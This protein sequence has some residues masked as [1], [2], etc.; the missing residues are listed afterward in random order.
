MVIR[1]SHYHDSEQLFSPYTGNN[2]LEHYD[3]PSVL[4]I[5]E[6]KAN[7]Y[8]YLHPNF[9]LNAGENP[10][11]AAGKY[12]S[13]IGY[14]IDELGL[15]IGLA[16]PEEITPISELSASPAILIEPLDNW[17]PE[18]GVMVIDLAKPAKDTGFLSQMFAAVP[19]ISNAVHHSAS[20][21][22]HLEFKPE[23]ARELANGSAKILNDKAGKQMCIAV[24]KANGKFV[25]QARQIPAGKMAAVGAA[26]FQLVSVAVAQAHLA[27]INQRLAQI[28]DKLDTIHA[29]LKDEQ[30]SEIRA[31]IQYLN[32]FVP[33]L[34]AENLS[35]EEKSRRLQQAEQIYYNALKHCN[36]TQRT[37]QR[38]LTKLK[39]MRE[40]D[41]FGSGKT[42]EALT[43]RVIDD[44]EVCDVMLLAYKLM[45]LCLVVRLMASPDSIE[46]EKALRQWCKNVDSNYLQ[47]FRKYESEL[48]RAVKRLLG[49]VTFNLESTLKERRKDIQQ[50]KSHILTAISELDKT[51]LWAESLL[52]QV[53]LMNKGIKVVVKTDPKPISKVRVVNHHTT[54]MT[55]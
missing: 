45:T 31:G 55:S 54:E 40:V 38:G 47:H 12:S 22:V 52:Q 19:A 34:A 24:S 4:Y 14:S 13:A 30:K 15:W 5:Y 8:R 25:G 2:V 33:A 7:Q 23:V 44:L 51:S 21:L 1:N 46:A 42:A 9:S 53:S 32:E 35:Q 49:N 20:K 17:Q 39:E 36:H 41:T 48:D 6:V 3:D 11:A 43:Q 10:L 16:K 29:F 18:A 27:E 26:A 28:G 37:L 50:K